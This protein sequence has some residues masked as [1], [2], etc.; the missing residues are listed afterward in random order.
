MS[1]ALII[2]VCIVGGMI[3]F[4]L[5][6]KGEKENMKKARELLKK[7]PF[8]ELTRE[9][10]RDAIKDVMTS[11]V[12]EEGMQRLVSMIQMTYTLHNANVAASHRNTELIIN[13]FEPNLVQQYYN[14]KYVLENSAIYSAEDLVAARNFVPMLKAAG[15]RTLHAQN[16]EEKK[17]FLQAGVT[18]YTSQIDGN[19]IY[20]VD[21]Y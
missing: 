9:I 6:D 17:L 5:F 12:N 13:I 7:K 8:D 11:A 16:P 2:I 21:Y 4:S 3:L 19:T 10:T 14:S 15:I 20:S 18:R 1:T